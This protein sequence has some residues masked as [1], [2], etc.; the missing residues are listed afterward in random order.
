[1]AEEEW[2]H[3]VDGAMAGFYGV[4]D[5]P[6]EEEQKKEWF[7]FIVNLSFGGPLALEVPEAGIEAELPELTPWGWTGQQA[8]RQAVAKLRTPNTGEGTVNLRAADLGNKLPTVKQA[9]RM[10][11]D[12]GG[13]L[14]RG[15]ESHAPGGV[16]THTYPHINYTVGGIKGTIEVKQ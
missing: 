15:P 7:S 14:A 13:S 4:P 11:R 2:F 9:E 8:Y 3:S 6:T 10:I 12:A 1:M 16:S 5:I